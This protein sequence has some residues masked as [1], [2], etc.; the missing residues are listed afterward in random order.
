M[1]S[2][3]IGKG[4]TPSSTKS[5]I[6]TKGTKQS[7]KRE[8]THQARRRQ[9][10]TTRTTQRPSNRSK[11]TQHQTRHQPPHTRKNNPPNAKHMPWTNITNMSTGCAAPSQTRQEINHPAALEALT[12]HDHKDW[13]ATNGKPQGLGSRRLGKTHGERRGQIHAWSQGEGKQSGQ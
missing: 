11:Q 4:Q 9:T 1:D 10:Q 13:V 8:T 5:P 6:R 3:K 12:T 2:P 7:S